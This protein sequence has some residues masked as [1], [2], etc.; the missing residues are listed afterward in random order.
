MLSSF[1]FRVTQTE[2]GPLVREQTEAGD[3]EFVFTAAEIYKNRG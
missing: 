3:V 1:S 2:F